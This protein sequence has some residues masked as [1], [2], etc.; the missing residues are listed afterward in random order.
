MENKVWFVDKNVDDGFSRPI[1]ALV[2]APH[3]TAAAEL[4]GC[5]V[6]QVVEIDLSDDKWRNLCIVGVL[7]SP[8]K[9]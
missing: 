8:Q 1:V 7:R 2:V 9:V 4:A 3:A 6:Q 5:K